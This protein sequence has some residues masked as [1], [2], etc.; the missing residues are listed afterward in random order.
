MQ[1]YRTYVQGSEVPLIH[2]R[3]G[4][5]EGQDPFLDAE[6]KR[7]HERRKEQSDACDKLQGHGI[8]FETESNAPSEEF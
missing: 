3:Y 2:F 6:A 5:V 7:E 1:S 8:R 4:F